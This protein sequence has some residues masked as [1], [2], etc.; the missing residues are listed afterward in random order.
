MLSAEGIPYNIFAERIGVDHSTD[1]EYEAFRY[2]QDNNM[3][4]ETNCFCLES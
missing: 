2:A 4:G 3:F 1:P